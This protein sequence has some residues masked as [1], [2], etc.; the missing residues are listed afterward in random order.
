[1]AHNHQDTGSNPVL[2]TKETKMSQE[3]ELIDL[4]KMNQKELLIYTYREVQKI[5]ETISKNEKITYERYKET[6]ERMSALELSNATNKGVRMGLG[7]AAT[8]I[9]IVSLAVAL[10]DKF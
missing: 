8:I 3:E 2:A 10:A 1:M 4:N 5:N 7:I 6:E 9:S